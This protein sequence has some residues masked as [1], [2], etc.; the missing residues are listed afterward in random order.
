LKI[1]SQSLTE[2]PG[3][4]KYFDADKNL[5][6]VGKAKNLKKRVSSY[7]TKEQDG[8][9]K[10]LLSKTAD[11]K[12]IVVDT[13]FDALLLENN[14][15]KKYRPRYNV[16]LKD[17]KTYPW[18]CINNQPFP[19]IFPTRRFIKDGSQYFGPYPSLKMMHTLLELIRK[20]YPLRTCTT[21]LSPENLAKNKYRVCLDYHIKNCKGPCVG[22]ISEEEYLQNIAEI[23]Q[24]INGNISQVVKEL[25]TKMMKFAKSMQF[26][27]A[28]I[29]KEKLDALEGYQ[30]KST[31][32]S[33]TLHDVDVFAILKNE[34]IF[35]VNFFK[36]V[37][38]AVVQIHTL[39]L[40][41]RLNETT[42]DMLSLAIVDIRQR[43]DS[44]ASEMVVPF[45]LS[46]KIP[47]TT[48]TIPKVG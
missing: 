36:V 8:K 43:F 38:G 5:L 1:L 14:L 9:T 45:E 10:V 15:I 12:H 11:I 23:K 31:V 32:F 35:Y 21:N 48:L 19:R 44:K 47:K 30:S 20:I 18:I 7:F 27:E 3:V 13:E 28:Q 37:D 26:E 39:E 41:S 17:D 34:D 4:Y 42:E 29:I 25:R 16:M 6:Y 33:N 24:I 22:K 2:N 46:L 40:K